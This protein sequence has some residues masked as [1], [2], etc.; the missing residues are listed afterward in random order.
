MK[1]ILLALVIVVSFGFIMPT[2]IKDYVQYNA[3]AFNWDKEEYQNVKVE[4][5]KEYAT[6]YFSDGFHEPRTLTLLHP[7]VNKRKTIETVDEERD[8][9]WDIDIRL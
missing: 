8:V 7:E 6:I 1:Y 9:F 4:F 5:I 3:K 2:E